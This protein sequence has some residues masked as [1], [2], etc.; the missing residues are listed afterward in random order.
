MRCVRLVLTGLSPKPRT[1]SS[2]LAEDFAAPGFPPP[3]PLFLWRLLPIAVAACTSDLIAEDLA[4][5]RG[6][7]LVFAGL[8][9][10]LPP[11]GAVVLTGSN[12]SGKT[13]LLRIVAGLLAPAAG[14]LA[15]G[16]RP[17]SDRLAAHH[18][19]LHYVGHGDAIKS[20]L[21]PRETLS[22]WVALRGLPGAQSA[23]AIDRALAAFALD[24]AADWPNRWLSAGQRR[25][26]AL[27][28]LLAAPAPLWLLDE[29]MGA[30]DDDGCARL[31]RAFAEHRAAGG[32][33]LLSTHAGLP[34]A[35]AQTI[36]LDAFSP[37]HGDLGRG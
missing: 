1:R 13:S 10:R 34:L 2:D 30:L 33:L 3:E 19:R 12:G 7:R 28:R 32:R 22:F 27:A 20:A 5:R 24:E 29:P 23:P 25:R 9:F 21:T 15:W 36:V 37:G 31:E 35:G 26:L 8:S 16:Q 17:V 4:C 11:C 14:R 6:E 18:A